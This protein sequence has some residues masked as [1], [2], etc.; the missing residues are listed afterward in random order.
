LAIKSHDQKKDVAILYF[1]D[2]NAYSP[3][4]PKHY[5]WIKNSQIN[6]YRQKSKLY[7]LE[8]NA[9]PLPSLMFF[10]IP[11]PEYARIWEDENIKCIGTKSEPVCS[12]KLN[13]GMFVSLVESKDVMGTFVGH[14]HDNDYAG[15]LHGICLA[16][17]RGS[18]ISGYGKRP[19]GARVIEMIEG[20][21]EFN[22]WIRLGNGKVEQRF[23]YPT[24]FA[25]KAQDDKSLGK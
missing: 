3:L 12:P 6:W 4:N 1:V 24:S 7:T 13:S 16:Y 23:H 11:L 22:S 5:G 9:K 19:R 18:G 10:H 14:D 21:R 20:K 17:G 2:S 15:C 25:P 8:N